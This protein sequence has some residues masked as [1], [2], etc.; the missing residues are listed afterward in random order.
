[1]KKVAIILQARTG[2]KR[3]PGKVLKEVL[4]KP[5]LWH[6][7]ERLKSC[8]S[9]DELI[10]A[11]S[12]KE[13][14]EPIAEIAKDCN[15]SCFR[16][17]ENDVLDRFYQSAKS[18]NAEIIARITADCPLTDPDLI[19]KMIEFFKTNEFDLAGTGIPPS[20]PD[21]LDADVFSFSALEKA[22]KESASNVEREHVCPYILNNPDKFKICFLKN[23][24]NLSFLRWTLDEEEDFTFI[25]EIYKR[26]YDNPN[27][28][29][30]TQEI[31]ELIKKNPELA[32]INNSVKNVVVYPDLKW[33]KITQKYEKTFSYDISQ[34]QMESDK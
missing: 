4:G 6:T 9:K 11:T 10:V 28:I 27:K 34:L 20:Y 24:E 18:I 15:I 8:K 2:S 3:L 16:G 32:K 31:L 25:N 22:W 14:D 5:L 26:L 19:D 21:G 13:Q 17:S 29:F 1:M 23:E 33:D 12:S 30:K 7:I